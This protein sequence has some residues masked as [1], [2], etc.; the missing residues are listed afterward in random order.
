M[1]VARAKRDRRDE[2]NNLS[3]PVVRFGADKPLRL[4]AGVNLT[5][6]QIAYQTYG[7]LNAAKSNAVLIC[8]ALTGDQHVANKSGHR[9]AGLVGS[10]DRSW[11]DHRHQSLLCHLSECAGLLPGYHWSG[12]DQSCNRQTIRLGSAADHHP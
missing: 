7:E 1:A 5:P 10:A 2:A 6:F 12:F 9:Q 4:E 3:S 8:H 11:K